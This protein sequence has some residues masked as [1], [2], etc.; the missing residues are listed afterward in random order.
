MNRE[1]DER[2]NLDDKGFGQNKILCSFLEIE[3]PLCRLPDAPYT[4]ETDLRLPAGF[5]LLEPLLLKFLLVASSLSLRLARL[6]VRLVTLLSA[7][8]RLSSFPLK[9]LG[10]LD[11]WS[12]HR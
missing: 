2:R 8:C 7:S 9:R 5:W 11:C 3:L 10:G 1:A 6:L 12:S 4:R